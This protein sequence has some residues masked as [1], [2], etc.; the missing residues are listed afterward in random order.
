RVWMAPGCS[1][2]ANGGVPCP[3]PSIAKIIGPDG[4]TLFRQKRRCEQAIPPGV[5]SLETSILQ[6]VLTSGTAAGQGL[7]ARPAAGKTGTG[8][9]FQ[10]AWFVGYVRQ[11]STA[12]WTGWAV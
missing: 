2:L 8:E 1:T 12:V 4:N 3:P 9:N 6:G 5:A 11:L 10:D 7:G